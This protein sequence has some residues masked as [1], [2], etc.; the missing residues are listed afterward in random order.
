MNKPLSERQRRILSYIQDFADRKRYPPSVRDITAGC[1][2][3]STSVTDYNLNKLVE[4]GY[5]A[6]D[7]EVSRSIRLTSA[8]VERTPT[9]M[10]APVVG[11]IARNGA[12]SNPRAGQNE[13]ES[14]DLPRWMN[15]DGERRVAFRIGDDSLNEMM[16]AAGDV[17]VVEPGCALEFGDLAIVWRRGESTPVIGRLMSGSN[18]YVLD[19][20]ERMRPY[21]KGAIVAQGRITHVIRGFGHIEADEVAVSGQPFHG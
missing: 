1:N 12:T 7:K 11:T 16:L 2:I 17:A 14:I 15:D 9:T 6:R 10:S 4:Y 5:I 8:G 20:G 18:G 21:D 13:S 3:S 19:S